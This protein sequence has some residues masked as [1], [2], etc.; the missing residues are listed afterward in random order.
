M[1]YLDYNATTPVAP[2]VFRAMRPYL[3]DQF[4]NPSCDYALGLAARDAVQLARGEIAALLGCGPE[5]IVFTSGAT[6]ANNTV[7][8]GV[9]RHHGRGQ[10][11]TCATEHPAVLAPCRF[12]QSQGFTITILPV[13]AAGRLDPDAVRRALTPD[14]I[15]ISVM[16]ANNETGALHPLPEIGALAREAG[17]PLHTDAAQSVGKIAVDVDA[18]QVDF[19]TLAGHKCYAP[20]GVGALYVRNGAAFTPLLHGAS[21]ERG[22]RAGTENVPYMVALG[23]ACRLARERLPGAAAHLKGL[24]D[25]LHERLKALVPGL[26]LNGPAV[27]RL[28]NTLNVSFP[29]V[30]GGELMAG[31]PDLAASLGSAC[32]AGQEA[33]S[34]VLAAMGLPLDRA[35]GA[36][37]FSVG[38]PTTLA[39]VDQAAAALRERLGTLLRNER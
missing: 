19:L 30:S 14:T 10:I 21:Q 13:D 12:L 36:V 4:G 35:R 37:R 7:L 9:A 26:I 11:I 27:E 20:K 31:L 1:I 32:H 15:L 23:A 16:H 39:D 29:G 8:K 3:E 18:L 5:A 24:R 22:R 38:Y 34:P 2:E 28:P 17:V 25:R 6:E 33:V